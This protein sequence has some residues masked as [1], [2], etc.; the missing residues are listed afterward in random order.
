MLSHHWLKLRCPKWNILKVIEGVNKSYKSEKFTWT[1]FI[2]WDGPHKLI[3]LFWFSSRK[4]RKNWRRFFARPKIKKQKVKPMIFFCIVCSFSQRSLVLLLSIENNKAFDWFGI[5]VSLLCCVALLCCGSI[6]G[7]EDEEGLKSWMLKL[8]WAV[9]GNS[10][11]DFIESWL[12]G[13]SEPG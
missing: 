1:K 5:Y 9:E 4:R 11:F 2:L 3:F 13:H 10:T 8:G 12:I 7:V 6:A